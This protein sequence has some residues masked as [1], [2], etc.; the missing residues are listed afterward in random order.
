[1]Y[2]LK[3]ILYYLLNACGK[4]CTRS[5][6]RAKVRTSS[7]VN[8]PRHGKK[9]KNQ[10]ISHWMAISSSREDYFI[11]VVGDH[12]L[13]FLIVNKKVSLRAHSAVI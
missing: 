11:L 8:D 12:F 5:T 3:Y 7:G 6:A 13:F 1:M 9:K 2:V 10:A 4:D